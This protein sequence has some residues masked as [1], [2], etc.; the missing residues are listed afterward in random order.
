MLILSKSW[1]C[2]LVLGTG[3]QLQKSGSTKPP[4]ILVL[5]FAVSS[6]LEILP[7]PFLILFAFPGDTGASALPAGCMFPISLCWPP[8][9]HS[10]ISPCP[11]WQMLCQ[12][13]GS[14]LRDGSYTAQGGVQNLLSRSECCSL[15]CHVHVWSQTR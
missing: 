5:I 1:G 3:N 2:T 8:A 15:R 12:A 9:W 7:L 14:W 11:T 4:K 13:Q 10:Q 6:S